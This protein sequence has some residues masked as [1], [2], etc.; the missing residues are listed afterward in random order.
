MIS[1]GGPALPSFGPASNRIEL[2]Y[3]NKNL[4]KNQ[5]F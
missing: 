3:L 4:N 2:F 5:L 1:G